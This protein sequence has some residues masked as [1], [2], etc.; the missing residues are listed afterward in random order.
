MSEVASP[1]LSQ[2]V[3]IG[4]SGY[5]HL[6]QLPA[7][8][9]NVAGFGDLLRDVAYWG[10]PPENCHVLLDPAGPGEVS[11]VVR[12]AAAATERDGLL[13]VYF[14]GH[15]LVDPADD[16]KLILA[17]SA[18]DPDAPHEEGLPYDWIRWAVAGSRARRR[19]VVLDCCYSGRADAELGTGFTGT[20]A[21]ADK[22]V[23][24][25]T[26]LLVSA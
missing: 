5:Q 6:P 16:D 21:V 14:S 19:L 24:D 10:I 8:R 20:D 15:G 12:E 2:V 26:C 23:T 25:G 18:C 22:A 4:V 3:L 9:N 7:V 1:A 13:L 11:R 17:L